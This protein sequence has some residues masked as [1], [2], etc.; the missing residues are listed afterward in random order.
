MQS[1]IDERLP[2][3]QRLKDRFS[4]NIRSGLWRADQPL[5]SEQQL[6]QEHGVALGTARKAIEALVADGLLL[7]R[8]GSGTFVRRAEFGSALFR[9]FRHTGASGEVLHPRGEM[10][11]VRSMRSGAAIAPRLGLA[12]ADTVLRMHRRRWVND[13]PIVFEEIFVDAR[14]FEPLARLPLADFGDLLYPLYEKLC[15]VRIFTAT[16]T[17]RFDNAG[18]MIARNLRCPPGESV[19]VIERTA[20]G[21]DG[22][23]LEWRRS[24]GQARRF[25]YS[26]ELR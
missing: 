18:A 1:H 6:A 26:I 17:I 9:F 3:Y 2:L 19:A 12:P 4:Q 7:R 11:S 13:E 22:A 14:R 16:E 15:D 10:L 5:P 8:Q 24:W 23:S 20:R 21:I 25:S